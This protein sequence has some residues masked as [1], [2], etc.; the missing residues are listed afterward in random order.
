MSILQINRKYRLVIGDYQTGEGLELTQH[1]I[2]FD[3]L[4]TSDNS[5]TTNSASIEITNLSD[6]SLKI[7][8]TDYPVATFEVGYRN[9]QNLGMIFGGQIANVSTRKSGT[10]RVTQLIL[11]SGYTDLNHQTL[12]KLVPPGKTVRDVCEELVEAFPNIS[13]GVYNGSNL[14]SVL[15]NGY[16]ISGSLKDSLDTLANTYKLEWR[17]DDDTLYVNNR[18]RAESENFDAA[19]VISPSSGLIEIPYY[20]SGDK[21]RSLDDTAKKQS[22]QFSMLINP[23]L[24]AGGIIKLED[25]DIN[26]WYKVDTIRYSGSWRGGNWL[27]EISCSAIEKVIKTN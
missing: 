4:K 12:S 8:E 13:R 27:Q 15:I 14:N 17:I 9:F 6:N 5:A 11:G 16:S 7:L 2:S 3:I 23:D 19:Y 21:R 20:T 24:R 18:D 26:G 22:V 25:T 10:D 1:Q